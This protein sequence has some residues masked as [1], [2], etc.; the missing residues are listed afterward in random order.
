MCIVFGA[1]VLSGPE[2]M[3][4]GLLWV[5]GCLITGGDC[6]VIPPPSSDQAEHA[7]VSGPPSPA[8]I[9]D[10]QPISTWTELDILI[11]T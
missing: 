5:G 3:W 9:P 7:T 8:S 2:C 10:L 1:G 11:K 4:C 6:V